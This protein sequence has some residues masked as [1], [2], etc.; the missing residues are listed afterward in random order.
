M[1][2]GIGGRL[3]N[4]TISA[5]TARNSSGNRMSAYSRFAG[6]AVSN[7]VAKSWLP[8]GRDTWS[9]VGIS[10]GTQIGGQVGLNVLREFWPDIKRK[11]FRK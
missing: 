11:L 5:V 6:V 8:P 10:S 4:A 7:A 9:D 3:W 1:D 2:K